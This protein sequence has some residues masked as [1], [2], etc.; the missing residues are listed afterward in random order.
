MKN[1]M[2]HQLCCGIYRVRVKPSLRTAIARIV[3]SPIPVGMALGQI[4]LTLKLGEALGHFTVPGHS[5]LKR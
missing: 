5:F 4:G 3:A 1:S 2:T